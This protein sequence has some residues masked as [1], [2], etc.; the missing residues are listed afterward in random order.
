MDLRG[1]KEFI[2]DSLVVIITFVVT[3]GVFLFF[4]SVQ[5]VTGNSMH[6]NY[7]H[8]DFVIVSKGL[9]KI[10]KPKRFDVVTVIDDQGKSYIKRIIGLP[11]ETIHYLDNVLYVNEQPIVESFLNNIETYSFFLEDVCRK[12]CPNNVIPEGKYLL[13]GDNRTES[14]DSRDPLFGL[15]DKASIKGK[16]IFKIFKQK[17]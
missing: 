13:L 4:I 3:I 17:I 14:L 15:R 1:L 5:S 16:V 9:S 11:G 2:K 7:L 12:D 6:P 10:T 8:G